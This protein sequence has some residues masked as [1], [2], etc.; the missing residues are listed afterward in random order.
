MQH[1]FAKKLAT[2]LIFANFLWLPFVAL[3]DDPL[4]IANLRVT[5]I[6]DRTATIEWSTNY[7]SNGQVEYGTSRVRL[8]RAT[9]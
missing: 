9:R 2:G 3:A 6:G 4:I 1:N 8:V 7:P 5:A